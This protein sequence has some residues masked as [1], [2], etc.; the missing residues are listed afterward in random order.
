MARAATARPCEIVSTKLTLVSQTLKT[1]QVLTI[2]LRRAERWS[3]RIR[4]TPAGLGASQSRRFVG[5]RK[6]IV[7]PM[8]LDLARMFGQ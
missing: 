4:G 2:S 3:R 7:F 5:S 1:N 6:I 8:S